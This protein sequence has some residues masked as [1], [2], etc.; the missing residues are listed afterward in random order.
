MA[1][2]KS[3]V[4]SSATHQRRRS[5][6]AQEDRSASYGKSGSQWR[7]DFVEYW[8]H[9]LVKEIMRAKTIRLFILATSSICLVLLDSRNHGWMPVFPVIF[10][11]AAI[12]SFSKSN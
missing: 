8:R 10:V 9:Y 7:L 6:S 3:E 11:A 12:W 2:A 5:V 1:I 4:E